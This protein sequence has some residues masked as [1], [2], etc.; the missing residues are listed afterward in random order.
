MDTTA[1]AAGLFEGEGCFF[2]M[3]PKRKNGRGFYEYPS[4]SLKMTD[5][6]VVRCFHKIVGFGAVSFVNRKKA[7][8]KDAWCWYCYGFKHTGKLFEMLAPFL[9]T[10]RLAA[11]KKVLAVPKTPRVL[12]GHGT[13][14]CYQRG[15]KCRLCKRA[16]S[17]KAT[18]WRATRPRSAGT[19]LKTV[20]T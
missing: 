7:G 6:D 18:T 15:C 11:G 1:W 4:A 13:E 14:S 2:L 12:L 16:H 8:Y 3:R 20:G 19:A 5:E 10:R 9:G 17:D